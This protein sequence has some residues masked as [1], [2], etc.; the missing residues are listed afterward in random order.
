MLKI[1]Y[2]E[3]RI[4]AKNEIEKLLGHNYEIIEGPELEPT[5][6]PNIFLGTSLLSANRKIL[7]RDLSLN[8]TVFEQLPDYLN[9]P[10]DIIIFEVK[11]DKRSSTYKLLKDKV[12]IKEFP[13]KL[14]PNSNLVFGIYDTAKKDGKKAVK[15]LEKIKLNQDPMMF[16]GLLVSQALKD[17]GR[18]QGTKEKKAL[19]ELSKLDLNLKSSKLSSWLL[20]ESFLLQ[21]S[22]L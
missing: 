12:E 18:R 1:F 14:D 2:G 6:L 7:I 22:T 20:I 5:D 17:Y 16:F 13:A 10:H 19:K 8:K 4:R 11:L 21:L 9:S 15:D 3:D